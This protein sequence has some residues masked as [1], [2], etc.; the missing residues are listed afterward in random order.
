MRKFDTWKQLDGESI[1]EYERALRTVYWEAWPRADEVTRD[2]ALKLKFEEGLSS[3]EMLQFLKL[4]ARQDDFGQTVAKAK[5]FAETQEAKTPK[6]AVRILEANGRDHSA[7]NLP[8]GQTSFQ[9]LLD[10]FKEV[11][12][13]VLS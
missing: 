2:A 9:P 13:T 12:Q 1:A 11:I 5:R 8:P 6:K 4:R 10:G 3:G 7:G